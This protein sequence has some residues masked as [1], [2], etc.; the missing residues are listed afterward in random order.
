VKHLSD[1]QLSAYLDGALIGRAAEDAARHIEGCAPCREALAELA[2]QDE[3]LAPL[4]THDPGDE[5]FDT[6]A[7]RVA[8]RVR[9]AGLAGAASRNENFDFWGPFRSPRVLAVTG[10][11][12]V[13]LV[14]GG[15]ALMTSREGISPTARFRKADGVIERSSPAAG[16]LT[17]APAE[18][19]ATPPAA[20]EAVPAPAPS[21]PAPEAQPLAGAPAP[22]AGQAALAEDELK[23]KVEPPAGP[24]AAS[25]SR[26]ME[27]RRTESGEE[28]PV[29]RKDMPAPAPSPQVAGGTA[30]KSETQIHKPQQAGLMKQSAPSAAPPAAP[31]APTS[32]ALDAAP[33]PSTRNQ[34]F[35]EPPPSAA[36]QE[37]LGVAAPRTEPGEV[38][39]CGSVLDS[40]GRPVAGAQ[41]VASD[42]GRGTVSDSA[43]RFCLGLPPGGHPL[44]VMAVGYAAG[45]RTLSAA[46]REVQITLAAVPV[47]EGD[48]VTAKKY[49]P[50]AAFAPTQRIVEEKRD[51]FAALPD[52]LRGVVAEA[53]RR[54]SAALANPTAAGFD[55]AAGAWEHSLRTLAGGPFEIEARK[56]LAT[57]RYR[58]WE[59]AP[60]SARARAATEALTAYVSRAPAGPDRTQASAWLDHVRP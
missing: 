22:E 48:A 25:P 7:A 2:A 36:G 33:Q 20:Y 52:S 45:R 50:V 37:K 58:A 15:L 51:A 44:S 10:A 38:R 21:A 19:S 3:S 42:L 41:V 49:P 28:V 5:Y 59:L 14:G 24:R 39:V 55:A 12:A 54:E 56:H 27:V 17:Q 60:T 18:P 13:V 47:L 11:V 35:A 43:G 26:A 32:T 29:R 1:E 31:M 46:E 30:A 57:A 4:L 6:F 23:A 16:N 34:G 8:D 53:Q 40:R 9:A